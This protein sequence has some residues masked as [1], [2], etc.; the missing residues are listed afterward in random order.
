MA[1]AEFESFKTDI[2]LRVYA[3]SQGYELD[4]AKSW[5]GSSVMRHANGEKIIIS[6]D[7]DAHYIYYSVHGD[8]KHRGSI[9]DFVKKTRNLTLGRIRQ[10]LRPWIGKPPAAESEYAPLVK[11]TKDRMRIAAAFAEMRD[12]SR[13]PYLEDDRQIPAELL[14]S[15]RFFGTVRI[16]VRGNAVFPHHDEDGLSGYEVKNAGFTGFSPGGTKGLWSS[17]VKPNDDKLVVCESAIDALSHAALYPDPNARYA[18]IGGKPN[19]VQ[20]ELVRAAAARMP[21]GGLVVAGMDADPDGRKL[22]EIVRRAVELSERRDLRFVIHEPVG[23]KDFNDEL[24]RRVSVQVAAN[25]G[26]PS[27]A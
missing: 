15:D 21:L 9:I 6:R 14:Q 7:T 27:L 17:S 10:E 26:G 22:A 19:P 11:T 24:C 20:P 1:D 12:P 16:D 13:H 3:A 4:R 2:D 8:E 23:H 18:S 25:P 5:R